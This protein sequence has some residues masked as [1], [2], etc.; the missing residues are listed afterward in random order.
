[1]SQKEGFP[2]IVEIVKFLVSRVDDQ[3]VFLPELR[4]KENNLS[5]LYPEAM[6]ELLYAILPESKAR[7]PHGTESA[8]KAIGQAMPSVRGRKEYIELVE[9][10]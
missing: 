5:S 3:R 1:M 10:N 7:W 4:N 8:L 6:L 2:E 9:R